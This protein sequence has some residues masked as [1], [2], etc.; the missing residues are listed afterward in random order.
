MTALRSALFALLTLLF[1]VPFA[2]GLLPALA[3][4]RKR[5]Q[6]LAALWCR[7]VIVLL[8]LCCGLRWRL[9]GGEHL[10]AGAA[11]IAAKHQSAW[12]TLIFHLLLDD[13]VYVLKRELL[14]VPF[15]GWYLRKAGNIA[16]D[17]GAGARAIRTM[18][19]AVERALADGAQVIVFPEGT[20]TAPGERG[21]YQPGI[22]ALY[23]RARHAV[24][25][26]ALNSGLFW[27]RRHFQKRPGVIT[28]EVLPAIPPGLP[29]A[30]FLAELES[31]IEQATARL[32]G[33]EPAADDA[34]SAETKQELDRTADR[35]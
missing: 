4:P 26:V 22:A 12:E 16:I 33:G 6:R 5:F 10:P 13:P 34:G 25:P 3:L 11:I 20:R 7:G 8:R 29:R 15:F 24:V 31:R 28:I 9:Q 14:S 1:C 27:R 32:C 30:A 18:L 23:G 19:P 35:P 17:R 21:A 2:L